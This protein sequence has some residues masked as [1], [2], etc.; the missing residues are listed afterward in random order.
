[1]DNKDL[2]NQEAETV[3]NQEAET[4]ENQ[5]TETQTVEPETVEAEVVETEVVEAEF[6][7]TEK[8]TNEEAPQHSF[9]IAALV[10]GIVSI[11]TTC[12]YGIVGLI[13]GIVG[14]ILSL[15]AKNEGNTEGINTAG[16]ILSIIGIAI[17]AI[18]FLV[19][20]FAYGFAAFSTLHY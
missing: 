5:E 19:V 16:M 18:Y 1:M 13:C 4:V 11:V 17:G 6:V 9:A 3:E 7:E 10:L 14:L 2:Q 12:C 8:A 15:K 20:I